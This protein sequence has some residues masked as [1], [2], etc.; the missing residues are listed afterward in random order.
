M[1]FLDRIRFDDDDKDSPGNWPLEMAGGVLDIALDDWGFLFVLIGCVVV[2]VFLAV[3]ALGF[4]F[5]G[6]S[7]QSLRLK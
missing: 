6:E 4:L 3:S 7:L 1:S 5:S 2:V